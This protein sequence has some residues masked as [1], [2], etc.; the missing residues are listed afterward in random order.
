M[1]AFRDENDKVAR[2][3]G[4]SNVSLDRIFQYKVQTQICGAELPPSVTSSTN[5]PRIRQTS[6][7]SIEDE[8]VSSFFNDFVV[9]PCNNS[10]TP[11]F[12]EHLPGL[13]NEVR[14]EGRFALRWAVLAAGYASLSREHDDSRFSDLALNCYGRALSGL[15]ESLADFDVSPDDYVLMTVVVLDL[16]EVCHHT[17]IGQQVCNETPRLFIYQT[18]PYWGPM[19]EAWPTFSV[20]VGQINFMD[21]VAGVYSAS[22]TIGW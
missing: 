21:L 19:L 1:L 12:L 18:S 17:I 16:F 10:S 5:P 6:V 13:F 15:G 2:K 7:P 8:A 9:S 22:R 3:A 14:V 4:C 20:F 11:G